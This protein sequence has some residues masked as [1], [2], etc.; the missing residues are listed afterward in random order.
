[1]ASSSDWIAEAGAAAHRAEQGAP[2]PGWMAALVA[3]Q[4][5]DP[6][7]FVYTSPFALSRAEARAA[8]VAEPTKPTETRPEQPPLEDAAAKAYAR[9]FA[10]GHN[11][12]TRAGEAVLVAERER[13]G[14]LSSA[15]RSL[16]TATKEVL[17]K[18]LHATVLT[19]CKQ[20]LGEYAIDQEALGRRCEAAAN[21]LGAG[22]REL[23]V[24]LNPET[25]ARLAPEALADWTL[26]DDPELAPGSLR[27]TGPQGAVR[28]GPQDWMR[29]LVEGL[30]A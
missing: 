15:F 9:G 11:T 23:T 8:P 2:A 13:F 24:H 22:P 5:A 16:D 6:S 7:G 12:A 3:D 17:A 20:V 19:L 28:D 18:D 26:A 29:A 4:P 14:E 21:R 1:M 30:N 10:D 25:R 27:L